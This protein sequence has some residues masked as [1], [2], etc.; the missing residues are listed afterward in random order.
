M[1][2]S[3]P[4]GIGLVG[5]GR[6]GIRY[7]RH[8]LQD[9]PTARLAAVCRQHPEQGLGLPGGEAV[10][11]YG[12]AASL[13]EDPNVDVVVVVTPPVFSR[14]ICLQAVRAGKPVLIEKPL[15]TTAEDAWAMVEA[16]RIAGTP[17]MTGQTL[18]FDA[19]IGALKVRRDLI[20]RSRHLRLTSH[21]ELKGRAPHHADGYGRRGAL[22]EVG[23]H[24]L[25]LVRF[26]THQ[27]VREVR[28]AMDQV[29]PAAPDMAASVHL[30]TEDGTDCMIDVRRVTSGRMGRADW[31]GSEGTLRADWVGQTLQWTDEKKRTENWTFPP[32]PTVL[33]TLTSFLDAVRQKKPMPITGLDGFR[34]VEIA[35]ACYR[36]AQAGGTVVK[37]PL[38]LM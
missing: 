16:A 19:T 34:A 23:V 22:L 24:L 4:I 2:A 37:L 1:S 38:S 32:C 33:A 20:G 17:L 30:T 29:P 5:V 26:V 31:T 25:D 15:A 3:S 10:T 21:I 6:H 36:S 12:D 11:R 14:E 8:I 27:E 18:R 28:C 35:E 9:I 7:A 13:I